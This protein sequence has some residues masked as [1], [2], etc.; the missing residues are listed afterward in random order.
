MQENRFADITLINSSPLISEVKP[1]KM[2]LKLSDS[3]LE[4]PLNIGA[5]GFKQSALSIISLAALFR[6][7][8]V[9]PGM[10]DHDKIIALYEIFRF[11]PPGD[12]VE[13]GSW[14]GKSA[15]VLNWLANC[16]KIGK[17]LCVDPWSEEDLIQ[18]DARGLVDTIKPN[19]D[20]AFNLFQINLIPYSNDRL[21][22]L[23]LASIDASKLFR[24]GLTVE[25][26]NFGKTLYDGRISVLHI[27]GNHAFENVRDDISAWSDLVLPGGWI[28][29][30]DYIW[31]Y[32]TGPQVAGDTYMFKNCDEIHVSFVMGTALF[33]QLKL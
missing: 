27:D 3:V 25:T 17:V 31:P 2:A 30:D 21:N 13:I 8:D 26:P 7:A 22:Y 12:I 9:I 23:R 24:P 28:I 18:N 32:G 11:T 6:H 15:F 14:W 4:E 5:C 1:Y 19:T 20:D 10:C 16:Y 29:I 33:L